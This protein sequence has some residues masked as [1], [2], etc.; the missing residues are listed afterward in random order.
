LEA[1]VKKLFLAI[2]FTATLGSLAAA[3][4]RNDAMGRLCCKTRKMS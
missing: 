4:Q 3:Q 2:A 1:H